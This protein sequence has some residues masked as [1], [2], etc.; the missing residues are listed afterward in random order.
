MELFLNKGKLANYII[1]LFGAKNPLSKQT[2][3]PQYV[4]QLA[5]TLSNSWRDAEYFEQTKS[6]YNFVKGVS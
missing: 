1:L 3:N 2:V 4:N 5:V 6:E